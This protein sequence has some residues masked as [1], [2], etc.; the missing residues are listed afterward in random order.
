MNDIDRSEWDR[1]WGLRTQHRLPAGCKLDLRLNFGQ[2]IS[3]T[4]SEDPSQFADRNFRE[5][6]ICPVCGESTKG[7]SRVPATLDVTFDGNLRLGIGVWAHRSC[8]EKCPDTGEKAG[9]PW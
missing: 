8:Y 5:S 1:V 6:E 2:P 4:I 7:Q 3:V 9:I